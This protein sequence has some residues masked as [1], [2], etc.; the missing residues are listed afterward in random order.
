MET[1]TRKAELEMK[2]S[3]NLVRRKEELEAVK[4]SAETEMLQA[5]AELKRQELMDANLLVDQL[6]EKLKNVTE[7][8]NQRNKEL[9]DI[10]VEKDNLK[11]IK[12][13]ISVLDMRKDESIERTF[14]GV[15][16]HFREVFSELVQGG[17]GFLVM[18]KKK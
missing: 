4:L 18:M 10:K 16:K 11:K 2:L 12:E 15:A 14:K 13:L 6:T 17:H 1:E 3:T 9:E 5:E 7:N 8:I